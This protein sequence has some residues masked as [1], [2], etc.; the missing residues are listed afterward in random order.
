MHINKQA[1]HVDRRPNRNRQTYTNHQS[2]CDIHLK[3]WLLLQIFRCLYPH[4]PLHH[5]VEPEG[6]GDGDDDDEAVDAG[7]T[8]RQHH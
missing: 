4:Q 2:N 3:N 5:G 8:D 6:D 1:N 7:V